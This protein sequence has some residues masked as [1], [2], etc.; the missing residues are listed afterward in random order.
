[1]LALLQDKFPP[2][3]MPD[4]LDSPQG[5]QGCSPCRHV[6]LQLDHLLYTHSLTPGDAQPSDGTQGIT[7]ILFQASKSCC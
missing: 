2:G 7:Q 5:L 1:M 6:G 3:H 4:K